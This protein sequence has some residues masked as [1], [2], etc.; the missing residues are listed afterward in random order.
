MTG[1][2]LSRILRT[3]FAT[4]AIALSS[5]TALAEDMVGMTDLVSPDAPGTHIMTFIVDMNAGEAIPM[6][7]HSG[8]SIVFVLQGSGVVTRLDGS[9]ATFSAG[10]TFSEPAGDVHSAVISDDGPA[11]L[12][13]TIVLPDGAELET[14]YSG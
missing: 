13:W 6:H 14:P 7:S 1:H 3:S 11:R 8:E 4:A 9:T 5:Q 12:I 2:L 10:D